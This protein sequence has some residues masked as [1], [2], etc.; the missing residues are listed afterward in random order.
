MN[1]TT[2]DTDTLIYE[3]LKFICNNFGPYTWLE[4]HV[5]KIDT[6]ANT[7]HYSTDSI[8]TFSVNYNTYKFCLYS[9]KDTILNE[10]S[11]SDLTDKLCI[12]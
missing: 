7:I 1:N 4:E 12:V 9:G 10:C 5:I 8:Y 2:T 3:C 11:F 6:D